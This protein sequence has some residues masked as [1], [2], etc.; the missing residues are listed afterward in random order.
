MLCCLTMLH[1]KFHVSDLLATGNTSCVCE[2]RMPLA[3]K[4]KL[5][6]CSIKVTD[7]QGQKVFDTKGFISWVWSLYLLRFKSY[8]QGYSFLPETQRETHTDR[9]K[10]RC[11]QISFKGH[12][13]FGVFVTLSVGKLNETLT[14][15]TKVNNLDCDLYTQTSHCGRC[16]CWGLHLV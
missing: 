8:G 13:V 10:T 9:T 1:S 3:T 15:D 14:D 7:S 16:C 11:P 5:T 6:I 2:T 12:L 4:W